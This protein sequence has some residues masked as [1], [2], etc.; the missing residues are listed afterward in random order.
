MTTVT[1]P[2]ATMTIYNPDGSVRAEYPVRDF[3][4][5]TDHAPAPL[6]P[7]PQLARSITMTI[8]RIRK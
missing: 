3:V 6:P 4:M 5:T 7:Y 8:S 1:F 2:K